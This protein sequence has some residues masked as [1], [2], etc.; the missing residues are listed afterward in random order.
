MG[1][2]APS[3]SNWWTQL[4]ENPAQSVPVVESLGFAEHV[5]FV[6]PL[7]KFG[8]KEVEDRSVGEHLSEYDPHASQKALNVPYAVVNPDFEC[9]RNQLANLTAQNLMSKPDLPKA[10]L[11]KTFDFMVKCMEYFG[12][13]SKDIPV[14][15]VQYNPKG[16]CGFGMNRTFSSKGDFVK[17]GYLQDE[18]EVWRREAHLNN[19]FVPYIATGKKEILPLKKVQERNARMFMFPH[20]YHF[21][22]SA[23]DSQYFNKKLYAM[24]W[25]IAV[26]SKY[27]YG[28][29][30]TMLRKFF[31]G[32][33]KYAMGDVSKFDKNILIWLL[34]MCR[35]LRTRMYRGNDDQYY[36]RIRYMYRQDMYIYLILSNGQVVKIYGGQMSGRCNTTADNCLIHL[37][38]IMS[39]IVYHINPESFYDVL[40]IIG[41]C[42]YSDDN[43]LGF[44]KYSYFLT[45]FE[46]R[47]EFYRRFLLT[48]KLEDD[49]VQDSLVGLT[50]LGAE[51]VE[52]R[53]FYVPRYKEDRLWAGLFFKNQGLTVNQL[54]A[55]VLALYALGAYCSV[56]YTNY[57]YQY[58]IYLHRKTRGK[59]DFSL[60]WDDDLAGSLDEMPVVLI[61]KYVP[62]VQEV[63][64]FFWLNL[65]ASPAWLPGDAEPKYVRVLPYILDF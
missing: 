18:Y 15:E 13:Y 17:H 28:G 1:V 65:E 25:L 31:K 14:A 5:G 61:A 6:R 38:I 42:I 24:D 56:K 30:D 3:W 35:R 11:D 59:I 26:G 21:F 12:V 49:R 4:R 50:F 55:K 44:N 53:G 40:N 47:S 2:G 16:S 51:I 32:F 36:A 52:D 64:D 62:T 22:S 43:L 41:G 7:K 27:Q 29:F 23:Q 19:W 20:A 48:L 34:R 45:P 9:E 10:C 54:F 46:I 57:C 63:R 60:I 33:K 37:F 8:P 39:M 58:L